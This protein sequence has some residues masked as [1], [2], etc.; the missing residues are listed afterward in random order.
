[1]L[2]AGMSAMRAG[3][4]VLLVCGLAALAMRGRSAAVRHGVW[5][6][7]LL[8]MAM[9]AVLATVP[10]RWPA[11]VAGI[12]FSAISVSAGPAASGSN[13]LPWMGVAWTAV[14][15]GLLS[16][17][18]RSHLR[19]RRMAREGRS[20]G[21]A[22]GVRMVEAPRGMGPMT[23]GFLPPVILV[24][25]EAEEW[26]GELR[27]A[28]LRHELAHCERGD[29]WWMLLGRVIG[30]IFWFQPLVWWAV[31]RMGVE[32]ERAADDAVLRAGVSGHSY[33]EWLVGIARTM[34][35][36]PVA[37]L[38]MGS[39]TEFEGRLRAVLDE[40]T[41]RRGLGRAGA[42]AL[43]ASVVVLLLP[44]AAAQKGEKQRVDEVFR[45]GAGVS[46]PVILFKVE[47][48]YTQEARDAKLEGTVLMA[49]EIDQ[50]GIVRYIKVLRPLG[51]G[52]SEK[53][54]E[55]VGQWRF[56]PGM[57]DGKPVKVAANIE[58]NFRLL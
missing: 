6:A 27:D 33:A 49:V 32:S 44:V 20:L 14:S 16:S 41:N 57:K 58:V 22:A 53:A 30:C 12:E 17:L 2:A 10:V 37:A 40:S 31:Y 42:M 24:P 28:V 46:A 51:L 4:A 3:T 38:A 55:A 54:M 23:W 1:M 5:V 29:C 13:Q 25:R 9:L 43:A 18:V 35:G 8:G 39:R 48:Q 21:A 11:A 50:D 47:P 56:R 15:L 26:D 19:A 36:E 45:I 34:R 7:G 52:M